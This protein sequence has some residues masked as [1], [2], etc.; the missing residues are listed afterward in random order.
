ML[1]GSCLAPAPLP[2]PEPSRTRPRGCEKPRLVGHGFGRDGDWC[3]QRAAVPGR[4]WSQER[5]CRG[6]GSQHSH[7]HHPP[8]GK[9]ETSSK[10]A[11]ES[12]SGRLEPIP[13]LSPGHSPP[14]C[15]QTRTNSPPS[16]HLHLPPVGMDPSRST[17]HLLPHLH[18]PG[19]CQPPHSLPTRSAGGETEAQQGSVASAWPCSESS[20]QGLPTSSVPRAPQGWH[21][22]PTAPPRCQQRAPRVPEPL[23]S[24][25]LAL[26]RSPLTFGYK[27]INNGG[28]GA[29]PPPH[30]P[31]TPPARPVPLTSPARIEGC[32]GNSQ[33]WGHGAGCDTNLPGTQVC[34]QECP[35]QA[36]PSQ[37]P[38]S[39]P[40]GLLSSSG[41][42]AGAPHLWAWGSAVPTVGMERGQPAA[43][44]NGAPQGGGKDEECTRG[45]TRRDAARC[46]APARLRC[47]LD[48][49]GGGQGG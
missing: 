4:G 37:H 39:A 25:L 38:K 43:I 22:A 42:S 3:P 5:C 20:W 21:L 32:S 40:L 2:G 31:P 49:A 10:A 24:L 8:I 11:S 26:A 27:A 12:S 30:R 34:S 47:L 36:P 15:A 18:S 29:T 33:C 16:A 7:H 23:A 14:G 17:Q 46:Q 48:K 1:P 9:A 41:V 28:H 13:C 45:V 44:R 19:C 35:D 6:C